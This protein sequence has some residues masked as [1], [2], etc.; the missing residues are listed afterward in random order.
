MLLRTVR[1]PIRSSW[2]GTPSSLNTPLSSYSSAIPTANTASSSRHFFPLQ[3]PTGNHGRKTFSIGRSSLLL[4][5]ANHNPWRLQSYKRPTT[6]L[7]LSLLKFFFFSLPFT[8]K[9]T[10]MTVIDAD[11]IPSLSLLYKLGKLKAADPSQN[12]PPTILGP[13]TLPSPSKA[14]NDRI[15]L[16]RG[17][18]TT[19]GVDA[20]VNAANNSLLGGGGVDGAIHRAAG[21]GL[22]EEC[23]RLNGCATG[24]ARVTDAYRLPCRKV[25]HAVGPVYYERKDADCERLLSNCYATSL[26]V[27]VNNECRSVAFSALSTGIYGYPSRKAAAAALATVR[28]FLEKPGSLE[29]LDKV[30]MVTFEMKDWD[31]YTTMLP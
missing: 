5:H 20:I 11:D 28:N 6:S 7:H 23:R 17:D 24:S 8:T 27:A 4:F 16:V 3:K 13:S 22:L 31:A 15:A 12:P 9:S 30:V 26:N 14:L 25:I 10:K 2:R 1:N 21:P 18:I 19:L 29:K